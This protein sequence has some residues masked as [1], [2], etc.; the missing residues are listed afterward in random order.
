MALTPGGNQGRRALDLHDVD[1]VPDRD[2]QGLVVG[3]GRPLLAADA[4]PAAIAGDLFE[5]PG[6]PADQGGGPG[7]EKRRLLDVA[8]GDGEHEAEAGGGGEHESEQLEG[9]AELQGRDG[10]GDARGDRDGPVRT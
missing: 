3:T 2:D 7:P 8:P 10:G 1:G 4:D 6:G 5:Y 9:Q